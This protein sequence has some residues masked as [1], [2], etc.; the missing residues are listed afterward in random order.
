MGRCI[1]RSAYYLKDLNKLLA[2]SDQQL[3]L[4]A[5]N[6]DMIMSQAAPIIAVNGQIVSL[7]AVPSLS[8][9]ESVVGGE[10]AAIPTSSCC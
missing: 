8:E 1:A 9:L 3:R 10:Q 7:A 4:T 2:S 5:Q 6:F